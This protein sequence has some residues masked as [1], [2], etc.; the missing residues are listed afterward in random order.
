MTAGNFLLVTDSASSDDEAL[1]DV[2]D[3][4]VGASSVVLPVE[5][6]L[7]ATE[8]EWRVQ[9]SETNVQDDV[10]NEVWSGVLE[11]PSGRV[12]AADWSMEAGPTHDV[13]PGRYQVAVASPTADGWVVVRLTR[14]G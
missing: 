11:F 5:F 14:I 6:A 12:M 13:G 8:G 10:A 3:P 2:G 4:T 9:F 1:Y 7:R